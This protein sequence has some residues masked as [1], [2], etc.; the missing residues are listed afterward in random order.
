MNFSKTQLFAPLVPMRYYEGMQILTVTP[1]ARGGP[2][3]SLTYFSKENL[4]VVCADVRIQ[5]EVNLLYFLTFL[6]R[7]DTIQYQDSEQLHQCHLYDD[8]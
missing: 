8:G 1:L 4:R 7:R 2:Q 3:G 6:D 5:T